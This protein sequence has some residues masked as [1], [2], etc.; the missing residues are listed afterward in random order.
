MK[1]FIKV[2]IFVAC[3]SFLTT[4][5]YTPGTAI[6]QNFRTI[7]IYKIFNESDQPDLEVLMKDTL[8]DNFNLDGRLIPIE[9]PDKADL[10]LAV[11]IQSYTK[12]VAVFSPQQL[13]DQIVL[14]MEVKIVLQNVGTQQL[15]N[16]QVIP[17]KILFNL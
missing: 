13:P 7:H 11:K 17:D 12:A 6:P 15:V 4:C 3:A 14:A 5:G 1:Q 8:Y 16:N 9:D 2:L 10:L